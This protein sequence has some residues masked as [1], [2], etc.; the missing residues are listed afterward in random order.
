MGGGGMC[1]YGMA[2]FSS[3]LLRR[4]SEDGGLTDMRKRNILSV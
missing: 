1:A 4:E 2:F 3:P